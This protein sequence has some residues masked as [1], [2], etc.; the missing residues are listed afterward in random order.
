MTELTESK[1]AAGCGYISIVDTIANLFVGVV[2]VGAGAFLFF[3]GGVKS[4]SFIFAVAS[5]LGGC[6]YSAYALLRLRAESR[7]VCRWDDIGVHIDV[8]L[9][10]KSTKTVPWARVASIDVNQGIIEQQK[11]IGK[12]K[13]V[14]SGGEGTFTA[15]LDRVENIADALRVNLR[16]HRTPTTAQ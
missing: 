13:I 16:E 3:L 10:D 2:F 14:D 5:V 11:G 6:L 8:Q 15:P 7:S 12:I 4:P 1:R 9:F